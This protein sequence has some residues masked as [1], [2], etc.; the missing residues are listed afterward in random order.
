MG[1][2]TAKCRVVQGDDCKQT[3]WLRVYEING[4]KEDVNA[5]S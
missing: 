2:N 5:T 4:I 3:L 1:F